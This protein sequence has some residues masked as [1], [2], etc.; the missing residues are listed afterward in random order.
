[1]KPNRS[2]A[3]L[4]IVAS[5]TQAHPPLDLDDVIRRA[6]EGDRDALAIM[7]RELRPRLI[8][9]AR[10][11][12]GDLDHEA[13]DVVQDLAVAILEGRVRAPRGRREGLPALLRLTGVF[14][15]KHA[16]N[17]RAFRGMD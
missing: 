4:R 16:R 1:M 17:V 10:I 3:A 7:F 13:D 5:S 8:R 6:F 15:R 11:T 12:L 2:N 14:A 9:E